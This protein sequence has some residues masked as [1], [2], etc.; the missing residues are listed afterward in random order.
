MAYDMPS[1]TCEGDVALAPLL[2]SKIESIVLDPLYTSNTILHLVSPLISYSQLQVE[3]L[4]IQLLLGHQDVE[5]LPS[6]STASP[7]RKAPSLYRSAV[8][9]IEH[10]AEL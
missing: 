8:V 1:Y 5:R 2:K 3:L 7:P 9:A 6:Q 10:A 4:Y